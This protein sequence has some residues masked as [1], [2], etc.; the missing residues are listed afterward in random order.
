MFAYSLYDSKA[1]SYGTPFFSFTDAEAVR[2]V[3]LGI[4][5]G[6]PTFAQFPSDYRLC[7]IGS[8]NPASGSLV[9]LPKVRIISEVI[10]LVEVPENG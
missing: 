9:A 5:S 7:C 8:F 3:V 10:A 4:R 6:K 2:G 1:D